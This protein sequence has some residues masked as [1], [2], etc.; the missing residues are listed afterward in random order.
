MEKNKGTIIL[1][2][3][4]ETGYT[5]PFRAYCECHLCKAYQRQLDFMSEQ[6]ARK[7]DEEIMKLYWEKPNE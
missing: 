5:N 3:W 1:H 6:L 7:I 2:D 4:K